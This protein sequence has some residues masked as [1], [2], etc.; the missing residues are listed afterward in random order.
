[1]HDSKWSRTDQE[2]LHVTKRVGNGKSQN[3]FEQKNS[4]KLWVARVLKLSWKYSFS[5]PLKRK[6]LDD[7]IAW[8]DSFMP[9]KWSAPEILSLSVD[10]KWAERGPWSN[11]WSL[12]TRDHK[13]LHEFWS[14]VSRAL[15]FSSST[16]FFR[17]NQKVKALIPG[18]FLIFPSI[19]L[20][21]A[22]KKWRLFK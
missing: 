19:N 15:S 18:F 2:M 12:T 14:V 1:M 9:S 20:V 4:K 16:D 13:I 17:F 3:N 6:K 8:S 10:N 21:F 7:K 5:L 22:A 11:Q